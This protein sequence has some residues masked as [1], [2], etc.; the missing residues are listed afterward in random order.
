M[1]WTTKLRAVAVSSSAQPSFGG[2]TIDQGAR[3]W[4]FPDQPP[5]FP[6]EG[7]PQLICWELGPFSSR[8]LLRRVRRKGHG[9]NP[10][11]Y[12]HAGRHNDGGGV[13]TVRDIRADELTP[14]A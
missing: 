12:S 5:S 9:I 4:W 8:G 6:E 1:S 10:N 7:R 2:P 11:K 13:P 14:Q 3:L